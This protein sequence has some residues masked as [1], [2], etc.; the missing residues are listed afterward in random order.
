MNLESFRPVSLDYGIPTALEKDGC[1]VFRV[2][3]LVDPL[4]RSA[5][6]R[7]LILLEH[8]PTEDLRARRLMSGAHGAALRNLLKMARDYAKA[9]GDKLATNIGYAVGNYQYFKTYHLDPDKQDIAAK[10]ERRR[11]KAMLDKLKPHVILSVGNTVSTV[12]TGYDGEQRSAARYRG[13]A[14]PCLQRPDSVV[15]PV[16]DWTLTKPRADDDD[17]DEDSDE[18]GEKKL[19][20]QANLL[21]YASRCASTIYTRKFSKPFAYPELKADYQVINTIPKFDRFFAKLM[22]AKVVSVDTETNDLARITN[23]V[24]TAQFSFSATRSF[25]LPLLHRD[26]PWKPEQLE[27]IRKKLAKWLGRKFDPLSRDYSYYLIGQ[28]FKFDMTPLREWLGLYAIYWPVWDLQ[29]GEYSLDENIKQAA[30][31]GAPQYNLAQIALSYGIT[32]YEDLSFGKSERHTIANRPLDH[33]VLTYCALDTQVPFAIHLRQISRAKAQ[34]YGTG[35]YERPFRKFVVTQMNNLVKIESFMEGRGVFVD[36]KW[37]RQLQLGNGPLEKLKSE[38]ELKMRASPAA[39]KANKRMM[40]ANGVPQDSLWGAE[41]WVLKLSKPEHKQ[42]LFIDVLGLEPLARGKTGA[43]SINKVFLKVH[44]A[45]PEVA[46]YSEISALEKLSNTYVS[47][48]ARYRKDDPDM[49]LDGRLRPSFGFTETVTGRSNSYDPN[50]QQ[51]PSRG[52]HAKLIKRLFIAP[53]GSMFIKMDYSAHEIRVWSIISGD[54]KLGELFA[55]GRE[56]RQKWRAT[57]KRKYLEAIETVGDIHK[58][59]C[60]LF[61][62]TDPREVTKEQRDAV[63]ALVFGSIYGMGPGTLANNLGKEKQFVLDLLDKFFSRYAKAS[64]WLKWAKQHVLDHNMVPSP[65]GRVRHMYAHLYEGAGALEAAVKRMGSNSPIQGWAADMGHT[66]ATLFLYHFPRVV[67][68]FQLAPINKAMGGINVMVHDSLEGDFMYRLWL[69]ALQVMQWCATTGCMQYYERHFGTKYTVPLEVEFELGADDSTLVKWDWSD[70][71]KAPNDK[72]GKASGITGLQ[73]IIVRASEQQ[74]LIFPDL[75]PKN[76]QKEIL[77]ARN[78][79]K[80]F[81]HLDAQY[82]ILA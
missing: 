29:A 55:Q 50:L 82:P 53:R 70:G 9:S 36:S 62:G 16:H 34:A 61:F 47:K 10:F 5:K 41:Q 24:L 73:D 71:Y 69:V 58:L 38:L 40:R 79:V 44:S 72:D 43:P 27:Y 15:V 45:V 32:A 28:N 57:E 80:L 7:V 39:K 18:F 3:P 22:E 78:N 42:T 1:S 4:Y 54:K 11:L 56:L 20:A 21:G 51:I 74:A 17:D 37:L 30:S 64:G 46:L 8:V 23:R 25:I 68:E 76:I 14:L 67:E 66:A 33:N 19:V 13:Y 52:K 81:R 75:K 59:N 65:I 12:L 6:R 63:K 48:I 35:T 60:Q 2:S 31:T 26:A 77:S 49:R